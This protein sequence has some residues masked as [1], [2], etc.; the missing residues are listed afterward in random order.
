MASSKFSIFLLLI[1]SGMILFQ[2]NKSGCMGVTACP[3]YC[4]EVAYMTCTSS[5]SQKLT[6]KCNCCL[7][8]KDCTLHLSDGSQ[9]NCAS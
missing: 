1:L 3:Q 2:D 7:A 8:P 5:G 4:L 6:G 9:V